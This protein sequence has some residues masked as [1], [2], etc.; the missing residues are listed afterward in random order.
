MLLLLLFV[1]VVVVV[2]VVV[3]VVAVVVVVSGLRPFR[4]GCDLRRDYS[5]STTTWSTS[6][7]RC[8]MGALTPFAGWRILRMFALYMCMRVRG[9]GGKTKTHQPTNWMV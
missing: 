7:G 1:V 8:L 4:R 5:L 2:A 3:V 6:T 9:T